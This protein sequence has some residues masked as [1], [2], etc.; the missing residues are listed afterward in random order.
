MT[1]LQDSPIG[2][3]TRGGQ[4]ALMFVR[5]IGEVVSKFA[6]ISIL[7]Y[8]LTTAGLFWHRTDGY[9]RYLLFKYGMAAAAT[10]WLGHGAKPTTLSQPDGSVI[11]TRFADVYA[12]PIMKQNVRTLLYTWLGC[13]VVSLT[14]AGTVL[15]LIFATI[16]R[17]GKSQRVE[18]LLRGSNIVE[19]DELVKMLKSEKKASDLLLAGI[20]LIRD[21][22]TQHILLTGSPGTGKSTSLYRLMQRI[23]A[24]GDR[25]VCYSPSG[26]FIEW[27]YRDK[28]DILLNPF[29]NRCPG[30]NPWAECQRDY[31]YDM[32]AGALIPEGK[33][34]DPFWDKASRV[35]VSRL[36]QRC[37]ENGDTSIPKFLQLL[38]EVDLD[39]LHAYLTGT[40]AYTLLNP[41][42]EKTAQ[43]IRTTATTYASALQYLKYK[44]E[45]FVIR[46]WVL[47]D[48][49]DQWVFLNAKPDQL[50][51]AR[52]LLSSWLEV[53]TNSLL[54]LPESRE[55][56]IWLII[57]ELPSLHRLPSLQGFLAQSRKF[58]GCGVIAFQQISQLRDTYGKDG[59]DTITGLCTTW[60]CL[61]QNDPPTA[62][63]TAKSFGQ[64]EYLEQSEGLSYG[65]H[66]MRDGVSLSQNRK[67]R[68]VLLPSEVRNLADLE[69][70]IRLPGK[71]STGPVPIAHFQM[72]HQKKKA[73]AEAFIKA[74]HIEALPAPVAPTLG[75]TMGAAVAVEVP[76]PDVS[77]TENI[78]TLD[79]E[80]ER[81]PV[82]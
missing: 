36:L 20:P 51:A 6:G 80:E 82:Q 33:S 3:F 55:R 17:F 8:S 52:S 50:D 73:I 7:C 24:R 22:E 37:A 4:T 48:N 14:I 58:G 76:D 64:S 53:F 66:E 40:P 34:P 72:V 70:Y 60:A 69:G 57:D 9:E 71:L 25:V 31:H 12:A 68:D 43:G 5:M 26:D 41:A 18:K 10:E 56:R 28:H 29:D 32:L 79:V 39:D 44:P 54:S 35:V 45:P 1:G 30:W 19:A 2:D 27:M 15:A 38:S 16:F 78:F 81:P 47:D 59:A 77:L 75:P 62:E 49:T 67:M 21:T 63:W 61:R 65:S 13:M 46:D 42:T 11:Q 74:K 23:R